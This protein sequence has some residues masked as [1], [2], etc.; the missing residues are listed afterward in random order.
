MAETI[1]FKGSFLYE[2]IDLVPIDLESLLYRKYYSWYT[3]ELQ[4]F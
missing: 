4:C 1:F 2:T 3:V